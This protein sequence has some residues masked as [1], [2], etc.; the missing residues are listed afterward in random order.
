MTISGE[1]NVYT[2]GN[3]GQHRVVATKLPVIGYSR[4]AMTSAGSITTRLLGTNDCLFYGRVLIK[5]QIFNYRQFST[6]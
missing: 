5:V 3:I 4:E 6:H 1:S 2:L